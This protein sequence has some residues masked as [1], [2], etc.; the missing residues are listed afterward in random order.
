MKKIEDETNAEDHISCCVQLR[1]LDL[2]NDEKGDLLGRKI[3]EHFLLMV[4]EAE[5]PSADGAGSAPACLPS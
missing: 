3:K 1:A 5:M 4:A 2:L